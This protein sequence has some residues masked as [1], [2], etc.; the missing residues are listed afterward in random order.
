MYWYENKFRNEELTYDDFPKAMDS[1]VVGGAM[2]T[3]PQV[4]A[5]GNV[6]SNLTS[7]DRSGGVMYLNQSNGYCPL[8]ASRFRVE[9]PR[10]HKVR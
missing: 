9:L 3:R 2:S 6:P 4:L 5:L 7:L 1:P 10:Q 8:Q